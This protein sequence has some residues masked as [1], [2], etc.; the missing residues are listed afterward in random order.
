MATYIS[1]VIVI[2]AS[3]FLSRYMLG[4]M[5]YAYAIIAG[6]VVGVAIGKLT[7]VYTSADFGSVK[8][9]ADQS[10]TGSATTIISG[11]GVGMM[12]TLWPIICIA[13]GIYVAFH[14]AGVYGISLSAVGMLSITGI[15][16]AVDAYGPDH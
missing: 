6:L 1:A 3:I 10:Q 5:N 13:I 2:V 15:T 9:I 14:F 7:E 4:S 16:V 12:S 8:K 11:L